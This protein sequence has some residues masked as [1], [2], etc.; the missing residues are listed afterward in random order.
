MRT[1][2][3]AVIKLRPGIVFVAGGHNDRRYATRRSAAA[4]DA[5]LERLRRGLPDATLVVIGPIWQDGRPAAS[6]VAL[7][8]HLRRKAKSIGAI[9]IDPLREGWFAGRAHR[10]I[11]S[12]G[13]HPTNAGHRYIA[14]RVI[15][16]L[17]RHA[18]TADLP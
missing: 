14:A 2:V 16:D 18:R 8:D 3:S 12:D 11:G 7:R 13:I 6:I 15:A 10:F 5:V 4:A 9:F 1:Q 17:K